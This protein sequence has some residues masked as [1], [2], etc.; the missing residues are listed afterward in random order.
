MSARADHAD[1]AGVAQRSASGCLTG[2]VNSRIRGA[3]AC[4]IR[5]EVG[6]V[7]TGDGIAVDA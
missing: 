5:R 3:Y 2:F 7:A 6:V 4:E 1:R